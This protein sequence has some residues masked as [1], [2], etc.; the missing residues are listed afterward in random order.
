MSNYFMENGRLIKGEN[1]APCDDDGASSFISNGGTFERINSHTILQSL[2]ASPKFLD[3][4]LI[5]YQIPLTV[6]LIVMP[7]LEP[8]IQTPSCLAGSPGQ[9]SGAAYLGAFARR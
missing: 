1:G 9:P 4:K 6:T 5:L 7:G 8:G 2:F 3:A